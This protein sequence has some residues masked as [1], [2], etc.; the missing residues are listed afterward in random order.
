MTLAKLPV[1]VLQQ[2]K[3]V[4][5]SPGGRVMGTE[6]LGSKGSGKTFLLGELSFQDFRQGYPQVIFDP[7]GTLTPA[8][9]FRISRFLRHVP[10]ASLHRRYWERLCYI[11]VG[12]KESVVPF[13][14]YYGLEAGRSLSE[15]AERYFTVMHLSHPALV[16]NAPVSWPAMQRVGVFTGMVLAS[17]GLQLTKARSLLFN[18]LEWE[19]LGKFAEAMERCPEV[20]EAVSYFREEYLPLSR[21]G[22]SQAT[23]LFLDHIF[24]FTVDPTLRAVFCASTPGIDWQ[25]VEKRGQT[26]ILDFRNVLNDETKRFAMLWIFLSLYEFLKQRGRKDR[27]FVVTIDEFAALMQQV[28]AGV[29]PLAT[30][31]DEFIN[32]YMRNNTIWLTVAHQSI[33]QVDEHLRNTLLS[34]GNYVFGRVATME[35]ARVLADALFAHDP[36]RVKRYHNVW[37]KVDMPPIRPGMIGLDDDAG[38]FVLERVPDY[39]ELSEQLELSAQKLTHLG[40]FEF[41]LRPATREGEVSSSVIPISIAD[42]IRD[43][44]NGAFQFPDQALVRSYRAGLA[45]RS[46]IPVATILKEQDERLSAR[47]IQKP[48]TEQGIVAPS[49]L[50]APNTNSM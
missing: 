29:N 6:I 40:L 41:M 30:L 37:G 17:L 47:T 31:L 35:E 22:K 10:Q 4:V 44:E 20:A 24:R 19:R 5:V 16:S 38:Y 28:T 9:L 23:A 15:I 49:L 42:Y 21:A 7:L 46:G 26:V 34:L 45:A 43:T 2:C 13:P 39:M 27:P 18:T 48:G 50:P 36:Y 33:Y 12:S 1:P 11:D 14:I 8:L 32:Q 25:Q 3:D